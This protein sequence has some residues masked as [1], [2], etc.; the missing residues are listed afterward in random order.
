MIE[1]SGNVSVLRP[2]SLALCKVATIE[3]RIELSANQL[4]VFY[5]LTGELRALRIPPLSAS[6]RANR[7]W[8]HTCFEL[9][10]GLAGGSAYYEFNFSPSTEW[11]AFA[12]RDYRDGAPLDDDEMAPAITTRLQDRCMAVTAAVRLDRLPLIQ[13]GTRVRLGLT[14]VIEEAGGAISY[15]ALNHPAEK[16]DFHHPE[17]FV[18]ELALPQQSA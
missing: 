15:W 18:L 13:R 16:P 1:T 2:F 12:F 9:F 8:E 4:T 10:V 14:A 3:A 11:A 6:R 7:L 5:L 17:S